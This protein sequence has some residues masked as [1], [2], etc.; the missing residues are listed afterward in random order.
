RCASFTALLHRRQRVPSAIA[1]DSPH[2]VYFFDSI[3]L[4]PCLR[5]SS[6]LLTSTNPLPLQEFFALQEFSA[7]AQLPFPLH[8]LMPAHSTSLPALSVARAT[9]LPASRSA[10]AA[11]AMSTPRPVVFIRLLLSLVCRLVGRCRAS[12]ALTLRLRL[13]LA[14]ANLGSRR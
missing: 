3:T 5:H 1:R 6:A 9:P 11:L 8:A 2:D 12:M 7:P 10:A 4:P 13:P 14:L